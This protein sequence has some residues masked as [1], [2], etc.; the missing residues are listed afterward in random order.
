[1][2]N[3]ETASI[4]EYPI[5]SA[6]AEQMTALGLTEPAGTLGE[7]ADAT[8]QLLRDEG[9]NVGVEAMY[10]VDRD[11]HE[12]KIGDGVQC[13]HCVLDT[14]LLPFVQ[15]DSEVVNIRSRSPVSGDIIE[16]HVSR[17]SIDFASEAAVMSFGV[18]ADGEKPTDDAIKPDLAYERFCPYVNAFISEA[19][20]EQWAQET[21]EAVTMQLP[22]DDAYALARNL[23]ERSL[24]C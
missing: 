9:V 21:P 10:S 6:L 22:M 20:Y 12:A 14:L 18:A 5:P 3:H 1:M 2:T 24:Y 17:N 19:E 13:F 16:M 11:R 7:W 23:G 15:D 4:H 8:T